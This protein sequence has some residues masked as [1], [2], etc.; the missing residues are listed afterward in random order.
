MDSRS[1]LRTS[2]TQSDCQHV[3]MFVNLFHLKHYKQTTNQITIE[4]CVILAMTQANNIYGT[5][6]NARRH[7]PSGTSLRLIPLLRLSASRSVTRT[8]YCAKF[9]NTKKIPFRQRTSKR[10]VH[11]WHVQNVKMKHTRVNSVEGSKP[12]NSLV[13]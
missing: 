5:T 12:G 1:G 10:N 8:P 2:A 4:Y 13:E 6:Y 9:Y 7:T 3:A 11:Q